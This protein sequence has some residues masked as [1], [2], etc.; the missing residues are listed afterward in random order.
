LDVTL[1]L[2]IEAIGLERLEP[3]T[4]F[5]I[6]IGRQAGDGFLKVFDANNDNIICDFSYSNESFSR[7]RPGQAERVG[8]DATPPT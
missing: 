4:E 2:A 8:R 1:D 5:R 6:L 7:V 3:G